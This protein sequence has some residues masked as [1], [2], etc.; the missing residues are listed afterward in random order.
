MGSGGETPLNSEW[1][2]R[3]PWFI[4]M[5][6]RSAPLVIR[7]SNVFN[8]KKVENFG[9]RMALDLSLSRAPTGVVAMRQDS[10]YKQL[11]TTKLHVEIH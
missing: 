2:T 7:Q 6:A 3:F 8:I 9:G 10:N 4:F 11:D 5:P 1:R